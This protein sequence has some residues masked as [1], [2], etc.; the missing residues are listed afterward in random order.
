[1]AGAGGGGRPADLL[2][3]LE[4]G[5]FSRWQLYGVWPTRLFAHGVVILSAVLHVLWL[6][7]VTVPYAENFERN[8]FNLIFRGSLQHDE[9]SRHGGFDFDAEDFHANEFVV[10]NT[11]AA[12]RQL[13]QVLRN[14]FALSATSV[15][16]LRVA[17]ATDAPSGSNGVPWPLLHYALSDD[18][19]KHRQDDWREVRTLRD[20]GPLAPMRSATEVS[21]FIHSL[22]K[23]E[24][25][26]SLESRN[27]NQYY[28]A[29]DTCVLWTYRFVYHREHGAGP[30]FGYIRQ[31]R[32]QR[33]RGS[34]EDIA[35]RDHGGQLS[36][37]VW[38]HGWLALACLWHLATAL[39]RVG[40]GVLVIRVLQRAHKRRR[41]ERLQA[42]EGHVNEIED[43]EEDDLEDAEHPHFTWENVGCNDK[44]TILSFWNLVSI[45]GDTCLL[46]YSWLQVSDLMGRSPLD[47]ALGWSS[48]VIKLGLVVGCGLHLLSL[49]EYAEYSLV[50]Y[51]FIQ[52][53]RVARH[54]VVR[55]LVGMI[56][57][58]MA[59]L[60]FGVIMYGD[61]VSRFGS[62]RNTAM[63]LFA[64]CLGDEIWATFMDMEGCASIPSMLS[65]LYLLSFVMIHLY[66][67]AMSILAVVE[68]AFISQGLWLLEE[69]P[70]GEATAP[71]VSSRRA[72]APTARLDIRFLQDT[73]GKHELHW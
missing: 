54:D 17:H 68:E 71:H 19:R 47:P 8:C 58:T 28:L 37:L 14:Y 48:D 20:L 32:Q 44:V 29:R 43:E 12:H 23:M 60:V 45:L 40:R 18:E 22:R 50:D 51:L 38:L 30:F 52:V 13:V 72:Q 1:M 27:P 24:L 53:N 42:Q 61:Q 56:P 5:P 73:R 16:S 36:P 63:T 34:S 15:D 11:S 35:D 31:D 57:V 21:S 66:V 25:R 59:Y 55:I 4:I 9:F 26:L 65:V 69:D 2:E 41:E 7:Q 33:C 64:V 62:L 67:V 39:G 3:E 10:F 46:L 49:L 6:S 70:T